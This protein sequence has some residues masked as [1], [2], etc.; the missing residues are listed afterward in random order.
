MPVKKCPNGKYRIG[1]GPCMYDSK[2]SADRAYQGYLGTG[3]DKVE[4]VN[5][6]K[7]FLIR[8]NN[9]RFSAWM[10]VAPS[11]VS[12]EIWK[13]REIKKFEAVSAT[14]AE[15]GAT[16]E[17]ENK[18]LFDGAKYTNAAEGEREVITEN[19][20][21]VTPSAPTQK[22]DWGNEV[23]IIKVYKSQ[24]IV[25]GAVYVPY[26]EN[27]P[28]TVDSHGHACLREDIESACYEFMRKM[29]IHN[30]DLQHNFVSGYG[31]VVECYL[32]KAGDPL[33]KEGT[34]VAG[35]KVTDDSVWAKI[36]GGEI[37]GFSLAGSANLRKPEEVL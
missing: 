20:E 11:V 24:R 22:S 25:I 8:M 18:E 35:V 15:R 9:A 26:D 16:P 10:K 12:E 14:P 33:F 34:W 31:Y 32:A 37:T 21:Q 1:D 28:T 6:M 17:Q 13:A 29:N 5:V 30:I 7:N 27:D 19:N 23:K 3:G 2:A 36:E 4:K